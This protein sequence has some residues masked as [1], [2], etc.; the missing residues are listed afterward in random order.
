MVVLS[1]PAMLAVWVLV[2]IVPAT[3]L[4]VDA[5]IAPVGMVAIWL[6]EEEGN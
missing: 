6:V 1:A 2:V 5:E 3:T 4:V